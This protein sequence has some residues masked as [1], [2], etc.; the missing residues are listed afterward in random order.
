M[1]VL[2]RAI[3]IAARVGA[4]A[5]WLAAR[6][7]GFG[8][9]ESPAR[10]FAALLEGLGTPFVK[11]GQHLS[12]RSDLLPAEFIDALQELQDHVSPIEAGQAALEIERALGKPPA[13]I[14]S[15]FDSQPFAAASIAQV[16]AAR[17]SDGRHV[18]VKVRRPG[19]APASP[20]CGR[21]S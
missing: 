14:F 16:H 7:L 10:R 15:Q 9:G 3:T 8:S 12:L 5:A 18:V 4:Y 6:R 19:I 11:L 1:K 13:T 2:L 20:S 17:L 21:P